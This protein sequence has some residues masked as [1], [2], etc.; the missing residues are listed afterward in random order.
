MGVAAPPKSL[1]PEVSGELSEAA[2]RYGLGAL[3]AAYAR[4]GVPAA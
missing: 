2:T 1:A 3:E 4:L